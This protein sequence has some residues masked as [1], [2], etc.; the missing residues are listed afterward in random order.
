MSNQELWTETMYDEQIAYLSGNP[1]AVKS[2]WE[3]SNGLFQFAS[4]GYDPANK[5]VGCLTMIRSM[6]DA[7][8]GGGSV[9]ASVE[10]AIANDTRLP[11]H[12][13]KIKPRHLS[14]F[15]E[16]QMKIDNIYRDLWEKEENES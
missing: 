8:G 11:K 13:D 6:G 10:E 16:W 12:L 2:H 3:D 4:R 14:A 9:P 5:P 15:K 1:E 7:F